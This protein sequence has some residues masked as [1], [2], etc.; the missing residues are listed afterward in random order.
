MSAEGFK[1]LMEMN[2]EQR[3]KAIDNAVYGGGAQVGEKAK[4]VAK[5]VGSAV[6]ENAVGYVKEVAPSVASTITKVGVLGI[7]GVLDIANKTVK[8]FRK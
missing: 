7:I 3:A 2:M 4:N 5:E 8:A 1:A 6:V